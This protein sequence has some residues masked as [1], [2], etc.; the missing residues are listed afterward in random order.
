VDRTPSVALIQPGAHPETWLVGGGEMGNLV[1]SM[2]WTE[3]ALGP[4]ESWPQSLRTTVSLC[5]SSHFPIS[6]AWGPEHIQIYNDGYWPICGAKHPNSMGQAFDKCWASAWPAVGEPFERALAGETTYIENQ[7]MFLDRNG[8]LEE[9]FFT[10][11]Y[12]PLRD[13]SGGVGGMLDVVTETTRRM[14]SERWTRALR[15]LTARAGKA[16]TTGEAFTLAAATLSDYELDIPFALFYLLDAS[17]KEARLSACTGI[18]EGAGERPPAIDLEKPQ[19]G[20]WPLREAALSGQPQHCN[21][22]RRRF[23]T[24][25]AG[26]YPESLKEALVLPIV[27]PGCE[28][29]IAILVAGVSSRLPL[30]EGYRAFYDLLSAGVTAAVA[31]ARAEEGERKRAE[32][33]AEIDRA[34]TAFFS[35]VSHEFRTPLTLM[36]GPLEDELAEKTDALPALRRARLETVYRNSERLL[37]LVNTLLDFSRIEAGR[38][39][40]SYEPMD[41]AAHTADLA[42]VFRSAAE[43]AGLTLTINCPA[44]PESVF[45]DREMWEK[46]TLNLL[47]NAIK[48]TFTGGIT[49]ALTW[50]GDYVELAVTDSGVGIAEAE[51]S[52]L[53][54][55]FHR[56]KGAQSRTHEGTGIGLALVKELV[57]LHGGSIHVESEEHRGS[58]FTVAI[59]TGT[60]HLPPDH[61]SG[62]PGVAGFVPGPNATRTAAYVA[63]VTHWLPA[64]AT[65]PLLSP[66]DV[67]DP[68]SV[69]D[70]APE[71]AGVRRARILWAD[72]NA[73]MRD[74]V[75]RLLAERYDVI[76]VPDGLAALAS[77][78]EEP[79]DLILSDGMMPGLDGFGLLH[80]LRS[81]EQTKTIPVILLSARAGEDSVLEGLN[82][83]A[84]D[85][86][87]KPFSARE[88]LARVRTHL[89]LARVRKEWAREL[90]QANK[91]LE[92]FSY[93]VSHDLRA[94]LRRID[95]FSKALLDQYGGKLD[96]EGCHYLARVR[97]GT[98]K[99]SA[100]I[101][102]LLALSRTSRAPLRKEPIDLSKLASNVVAE[103]RDRDPS[104]AVTVRIADGLTFRGDSRL[105]SVVLVN[106]LGNAWKFTARNPDAE[107]AVGWESE[108][109]E[110][111]FFVKDNGAG[112]DMARAG[113]L[114]APFQRLHTESEFEGSGIGLATV[115][116]II[117][118]HGGTIRAESS[119]GKG[120][121]FFFTAGET[122]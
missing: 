62:T 71:I 59:K 120:A 122:R 114:F 33:L 32:A 93:S 112:F 20:S 118:R 39:Q 97:A 53:F 78:R 54:D 92:A 84:D 41:L 1:R 115:Q 109:G 100:L 56:V 106:L 74:Y 76:A 66:A 72:D 64:G 60:L 4:I 55:R 77:A 63:E 14:L 27:P 95:G 117:S 50:R 102:D 68:F 110:K 7:P 3:T 99:M 43:R 82:A 6:L 51:I 86:L 116:R 35:N 107:I 103:L 37:K 101:D 83:G 45:V 58:T 29:P 80:E 34:K 44:L 104:R 15:D 40:A 28:K 108:A 9:T 88:L 79:P 21:D 121:T 98:Q 90:E 42:S 105:I 24:L 75:R 111:V 2:D 49:V 96:A 70:G 69:R 46:I 47:S 19:Q 10:F 13:E 18:K 8:Y 31:N 25:S 38:V 89:D 61:V 65:E 91:E 87:A 73:D 26:P 67:T 23:P 11:S 12:S 85:Y 119:V 36:L 57:L 22:L 16:Q 48:H 52:H 113:N 5:L 94:P 17:G 81:H 30:N